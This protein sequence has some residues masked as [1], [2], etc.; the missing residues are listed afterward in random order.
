ML[1]PRSL[2][3]NRRLA[4]GLFVVVFVLLVG[5][6]WQLARSEADGR[7][8][9]R[10][11]F[12]DRAPVATSVVN[13]ILRTA[14]NQQG[15]TL[16]PRLGGERVPRATLDALVHQNKGISATVLDARGR[17][18]GASRR[19][20]AR[21]GLARFE[22]VALKSGYGLAPVLGGPPATISSAV[23]VRTPSG[24]RLLV[25][26]SPAKGFTT[27][28][29]GTLKP[30]VGSSGGGGALIVDGRGRPVAAVGRAAGIGQALERRPEART[31]GE[32]KLPGGAR[33]YA[34]SPITGSDW[35]TVVVV[36][37]RTLYA[38]AGGVGSW[39]P[40]AILG[41]LM[42]LLTSGVVLIL[43]LAETGRRLAGANHS[44]EA[45]NQNLERSNADLE[46]F[47]YVASH[48]LS[49]PLR[50]VSSFSRMLSKR[51]AE[52]LDPEAERWIGFIEDGVDRMQRIIDDL[53]RYS[54]VNQAALNLE[55]VDLNEVMEEVEQA[56]APVLDERAAEVSYD[57]LPNV[58]AEHTHV[59]QVLQNLVLN[60]TTYVAPGV[61]PRVH[62]SA[63]REGSMCRVSVTDNGIGIEPEHVERIFK[64]FQ[65]LHDATEHPGS[66]IGLA[67]SRKI[68][69]RHGGRLE[70]EPAPGGGS[71]FSFTV[72]PAAA[73]DRPGRVLE[74]AR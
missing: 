52:Q 18:L 61:T 54:R 55:P 3:S 72:A 64:M 7:A 21:P 24:V 58:L 50:S 39:L 9:L 20:T 30:L 47:A 65:R 26:T 28:L 41:L 17:V 38:P 25:S 33:Y 15:Q 37:T 69:E 44:L 40:W 51:H 53:L 62:V 1:R 11:R 14:F 46:Q 2:G 63:R 29:G 4:G 60:G 45:A 34:T 16:G 10:D 32:L 59:S 12:A 19:A 49:S 5:I 66:G 22:R 48:D 56:L 73:R 43:R 35:R 57:R 13:S 31:R 68:V 70:V 27:F 23:R 8:A 36:P 71:T 42:V 67:I 6:G 74:A